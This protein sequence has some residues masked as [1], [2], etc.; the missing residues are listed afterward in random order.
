MQDTAFL[1]RINLNHF[2][3]CCLHA[4]L[5]WAQ[6]PV[7]KKAIEEG[8]GAQRHQGPF[9]RIPDNETFRYLDLLPGRKNTCLL[10]LVQ[11]Q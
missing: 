2:E 3:C 10:S 5:R 11:A 8:V 9:H 7:K 4:S 1:F 6:D